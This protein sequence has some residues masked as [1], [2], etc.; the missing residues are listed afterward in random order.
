[1]SPRDLFDLAGLAHADAINADAIEVFAAQAE[2]LAADEVRC[3]AA[4][5][6]LVRELLKRDRRGRQELRSLAA[7][8]QVAA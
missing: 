5:R 8:L 4:A 6:M 2:H 3:Q 1:M 7:R